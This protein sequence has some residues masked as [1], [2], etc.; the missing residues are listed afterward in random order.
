MKNSR[1]YI[2]EIATQSC[3]IDRSSTSSGINREVYVV[4]I[5]VLNAF[6]VCSTWYLFK[7]MLY[8]VL[9]CMLKLLYYYLSA[10]YVVHCIIQ[11]MYQ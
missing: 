1:F 3:V 7:R 8:V 2:I 10:S 6:Y 4:R 11:S 9:Q 5:D